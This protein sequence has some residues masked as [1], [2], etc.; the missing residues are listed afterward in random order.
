MTE[1]QF[2]EELKRE[3]KR[4][5]VSDIDDIISEYVQHFEY[6]K[7]EGKTEEEIARRL[8]SPQEIANDYGEVAEEEN[9][10]FNQKSTAASIEKENFEITESENEAR[11]KSPEE[12]ALNRHTWL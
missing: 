6:K 11:A 1:N 5:N 10:V 2:I 7:Q 4:R 12:T 8:S 9:I 3:L